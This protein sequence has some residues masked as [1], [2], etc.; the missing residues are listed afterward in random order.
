M[1]KKQL[2]KCGWLI[3]GSGSRIKKNIMIKIEDGTITDIFDYAAEDFIETISTDFSNDTILPC[4]ID[5][6]VHLSLIGDFINSKKQA[7]TKSLYEQIKKIIDNNIKQHLCYGIIAVRDGGCPNGYVI[8]FLKENYKQTLQILS[9]NYALYKQGRYGNILGKPV[10]SELTLSQAILKLSSINHVKIINSGINSISVFGKETQP[11]FDISE[12]KE[13]VNT[14]RRLGLKTMVH[15]NGK[16]PVHN[17]LDS[18]CDSIE[19]GYFMGEDN[20]KIMA[21]KQIFW[22]PTVC[23]M[24]AIAKHE[25]YGKNKTDIA[26]QTLDSQIEQLS[27]AQEIGVKL[28]IGTDSGSPGVKHG[29]SIIKEIALFIK[30]GFTIEET[31][32]C[33][34][35][36]GA[37]LLNLQYSGKILKGQNASF[38][39]CEGNPDNLP[40]SIENIKAFYINGVNIF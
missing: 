2:I 3:D 11:Q 35:V 6:H 9:P 4:L 18:N 30:A 8:N 12:L 36:N 33:A 10:P 29:E 28:A 24:E 32:K 26:K 23:P 40:E 17:S 14:A 21:D 27:K 25:K 20:L 34:S 15:A 37:E 7:E 22:V 31:I 5:A 16:I 19:H 38:I 13:A 39:V 1:L